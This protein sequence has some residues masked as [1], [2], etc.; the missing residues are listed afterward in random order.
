MAH[1]S[2]FDYSSEVNNTPIYHLSSRRGLTDFVADFLLQTTRG[3]LGRNHKPQHHRRTSLATG[4]STNRTKHKQSRLHQYRRRR[5]HSSAVV[6]ERH[7]GSSRKSQ[8]RVSSHLT[9]SC[10]FTTPSSNS[11]AKPHAV[12]IATMAISTMPTSPVP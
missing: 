4:M 1:S 5:R 8:R 6:P 9:P 3:P 2:I 10:S 7:Q 12:A 11:G